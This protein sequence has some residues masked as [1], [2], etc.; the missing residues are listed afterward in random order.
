M[1]LRL[2]L[3]SF[4]SLL[5]NGLLAQ[6]D[7]LLY[8][9][10]F[11]KTFEFQSLDV[12][13]LY[14]LK[15]N[16]GVDNAS[17]FP[18]QT[19]VAIESQITETFNKSIVVFYD[20]SFEFI[21]H[22]EVYLGSPYVVGKVGNGIHISS[23]SPSLS[24]NDGDSF[25][26]S[27]PELTGSYPEEINGSYLLKYDLENNTLKMPFHVKG[28]SFN[29]GTAE[30]EH[31]PFD[32]FSI[33][34]GLSTSL[35]SQRDAALMNDGFIV[36]AVNNF[37]EIQVN[38]EDT[39]PLNE[40]DWGIAWARVNP[41]LENNIIS[42]MWSDNGSCLNFTLNGSEDGEYVF[43][44]GVLKGENLQMNPDGT[45]W[46][47]TPDSI[48]YTFLLKENGLGE[49]VWMRPIYSYNSALKYQH[50]S[51][52]VEMAG[53]L[54]L[55]YAFHISSPVDNIAYYN[56]YMG[57]EESIEVPD[58]VD[59]SMED[60]FAAKAGR[61]I[62]QLDAEGNL[63]AKL[64]IRESNPIEFD[65]SHFAYSFQPAHLFKVEDKLAW[66]YTLE[67]LNDTTVYVVKQYTDGSLDSAAVDIPSGRNNFIIWLNAELDILEVTNIPFSTNG[68]S[69]NP[70]LSLQSVSVFGEDSL[71]LAGTIF[72]GTTTS[73]D[74]TG[75]AVD[76]T[77][78]TNTG[79]IA[80]YGLPSV[81]SDGSSLYEKDKSAFKLYPNPAKESVRIVTDLNQTAEYRIVNL[82]GTV[83]QTGLIN[84][85]TGSIEIQLNGLSPG[86]YLMSLD[87]DTERSTWTEK[88]VVE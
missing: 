39:L 29:S 69:F 35:R 33:K 81:L 75:L 58:E 40:N 85:Q 10:T 26:Q 38:W 31:E 64:M 4:F 82:M 84:V 74:P 11:E 23:S 37:A 57:D 45:M 9:K 25:F 41:I 49:Q 20:E 86:L 80:F 70:G 32:S 51:T 47:Q 46:E 68:N 43:R 63:N 22:F 53:N 12:D 16:A 42:P 52:V 76:I 54:Y 44:T 28:K 13:S 2:L 3:I 59:T 15:F 65:V 83:V 27:I 36:K 60:F 71:M 88:L 17:I 24:L 56:D 62:I 14:V 87:I 5:V 50:A 19:A 55:Q 79:F 7:Q 72:A 8:L 18:N 61:E 1:K 77:Y 30:L 21:N 78:N 66:P 67:C 34:A 6:Q 73:L 48:Y